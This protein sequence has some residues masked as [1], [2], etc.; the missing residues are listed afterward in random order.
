M[1]CAHTIRRLKPG[2]FEQFAEAFG[3]PEEAAS[4]GWVGF[5][6]LRG[7]SDPDE[8]VTFGFFDGSLGHLEASQRDLGYQERRSMIEPLVDEVIANG[9]FDV[10]Q[11]RVPDAEAPRSTMP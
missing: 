3:P 11:S 6:M 8:V 4:A 2:T 5:Y 9:V 1:L 7:I 10:V